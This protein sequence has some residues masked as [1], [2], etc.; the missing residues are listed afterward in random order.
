MWR[1]SG[2]GGRLP[3]HDG[4]LLPK[5]R[6]AAPA[7]QQKKRGGRRDQ[8][9][10][11]PSYCRASPAGQISLSKHPDGAWDGHRRRR[12]GL[13]GVGGSRCAGRMFGKGPHAGRQPLVIVPGAQ[14]TGGARLASG[15]QPTLTEEDATANQRELNDVQWRPRFCRDPC[16]S[17]PA[18][19]TGSLRGWSQS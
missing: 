2:L 13:H 4:S 14:N 3:W 8:S 18:T 11:I 7:R 1:N 17:W 6:A 10:G 19:R 12:S 15:T 9:P 16:R 5:S